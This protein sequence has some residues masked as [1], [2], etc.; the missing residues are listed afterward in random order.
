MRG[1]TL[2]YRFASPGT[3]IALTRRARGGISSS[4]APGRI[5]RSAGKRR[6]QR[7]A[8]PLCCRMGAVLLPFSAGDPLTVYYH[9]ADGVSSASRAAARFTLARGYIIIAQTPA[10]S[11]EAIYEHTHFDNRTPDTEALHRGRHGRAF[12][13][14]QGRDGQRIPALVS[15]KGHGGNKTVLRGTVRRQICPAAGVCLRH[16]PERR[17]PHRL[18]QRGYGGA[19]RSRLRAF[20]GIL[21]QGHR[22]GGGAGRHRAAEKGRPA[23]HPATLTRAALP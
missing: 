19:L 16:L 18:Y 21:A 5:S 22:N 20:A 4:R 10:G 3:L 15:R 1:S 13:D 23:P 6:S 2:V 7:S 12:P 9:A 14:T 17:R 11:R 8:A